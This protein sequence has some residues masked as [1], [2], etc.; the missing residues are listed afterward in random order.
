MPTL[1]NTI[2]ERWAALRGRSVND[3][4][5]MYLN[6]VRK[7]PFCG[8]KVFLTCFKGRDQ[9]QFWIA[10]QE[11]GIS[12]LDHTSLQPISNFDF[13]SVVTFG[14]WKDDFMLVVNQLIESAPH[15]YEHRTEKML[16]VLPKPKILELSLLIAS[17]INSRLQHPSPDSADDI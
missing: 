10:V 6:V 5:R 15:H 3:C 16:F 11:E 1:V 2:Y 17:Y 9:N 8:A 12:L 4:V 13:K 14:G 7:W